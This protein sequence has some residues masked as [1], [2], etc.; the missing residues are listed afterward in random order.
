MGG[1]PPAYKIDADGTL[2]P[3]WYDVKAWGKRVWAGVIAG[4]VIII[5]IV[6]VVAVVVS[7]KNKYPD[8]SKL[9]Y[10]LSE[11]YSGSTFFDQFD[12]FT[13][14][15]PS[16]GFVHYVDSSVAAQYNLTYAS[17]SSAIMRVDTSVTSTTVPNAS[18]GRFSVRI[19]SKKQYGLNNLFVFDVKHTP[20]GCGTWPALWLS[21]PA[22]W[23][24]NGEIDIMEAVNVVSDAQN[25]MTL[26]TSSGCSMSVKRKETGKSLQSSCVNTT[27]SN[28][29]CGVDAGTSTFGSSFN[30]A[31]G[32]VMA[33]ELRSAGIRMWQFGRSNIPS[34]VTAGSPDPSTWGEATADFPNTDCN[35]GN[36]FRNQSII[37]NIDLCG[38]WAGTQSVYSQTCSGTCEDQVANN[39]TAFTNAYWEFGTFKVYSAST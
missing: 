5:I 25:Q 37:A 21:D 20:I 16:A 33:M 30:S 22:N 31:G 2:S 19:T 32:G 15:D 18:T 29:G 14:Y 38:S 17:S 13:G 7:K 11:T 26:H 39:N 3:R 24:T 35:I 36:H 27:N 1:P 4:I 10:S 34:D 12:Y 8:Y 23:P 28:A 9:T 6:V